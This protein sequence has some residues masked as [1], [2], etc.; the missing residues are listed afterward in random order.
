M[1]E[2]HVVDTNIV[3][4]VT[5]VINVFVGDVVVVVIIADVFLYCLRC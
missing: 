4:T 2:V 1:L 3:V 5:I